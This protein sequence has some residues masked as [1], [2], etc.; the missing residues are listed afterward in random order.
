MD[1]GAADKRGS[2]RGG[3]ARAA[4]KKGGREAAAEAKEKEERVRKEDGRVEPEGVPKE[5][6]SDSFRALGL[7]PTLLEAVEA[8]G[9]SQPTPIQQQTIPA[10]LRD[11]RDVIGVAK[12]GSGKTGAFALPILHALLENPRK[13]FAVVLAPTR[14]LAVQIA[15]QFRALGAGIDLRVAVLLGGMDMMDQAVQLA[16][17]PHV[18]V[19]TPGRLVDHLQNTKGFH[20]R[21]VH[22]LVM[23]EADRM[24]SMDFEEALTAILQSLPRERS[25]LLFS[26]TM[27]AQV[28][29]LQRASLRD[30]VRIHADHDPS[31]DGGRDDAAASDGAAGASASASSA[32]AIT[33]PST[34]VA[35][36]VLTPADLKD[37][38]LALLL[39]DFAGQS[40]LVFT[41]TCATSQRL[42]LMLRMLGFQAVCLHGKMSQALRLGA[43]RKF[44]AKE[45]DIL[46]AT[47]VAS[48]G[49]DIPHVDLV[50]NYDVPTNGKDYVHRVGRTARAGRAGRAVTFV[51]QYD[52]EAFKRIEDMLSVRLPAYE[53]ASRERALALHER[54]QEAN[55]EAGKQLKEI[56][57][58]EGQRKRGAKRPRADEP[59]TDSSLAGSRP[60]DGD[61]DDRDDE[62]GLVGRRRRK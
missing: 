3:G 29:K 36:Y 61:G 12:T 60:R 43:L 33:L 57:L 4:G 62:I 56:E 17:G 48:R 38:N 5:A 23:D 1:R 47:D 21:S 41:S 15:D 8:M 22:F 7:H 35:Q 27:T 20:L 16:R 13:G 46:I 39:T 44:R 30:P 18:I 9:W 10:I 54:V 11:K 51:S 14:E 50:L 55:R 58:L 42:A 24:L 31:D 26:A 53:G 25:T 32:T 49:L 6:E 28:A 40:V 45:R 59:A 37:A 2:A 19:A 34:L 52:I